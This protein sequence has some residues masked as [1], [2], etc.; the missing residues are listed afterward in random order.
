MSEELREGILALRRHH[1]NSRPVNQIPI[2]LLCKIFGQVQTEYV[3][4]R[5]MQIV[6]CLL[7]VCHHWRSVIFEDGSLWAAIKSADLAIQC[8]KRSHGVPLT[9]RFP[10]HQ[11]SQRYLR[12]CKSFFDELPHHASRIEEA[13]ITRVSTLHKILD[14]SAP[15]L[16]TLAV[17]DP[18]PRELSNQVLPRLFQ[19]NFPSL[20]NLAIS[21]CAS[22]PGSEFSNLFAIALTPLV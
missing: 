16:R 10:R 8:L 18:H 4:G 11:D 14:F 3:A 17:S 12:M 5:Q 9:L 6:I 13:I 15:N 1:N 21:F 7:A 2:E 22:W 19:G 20:K